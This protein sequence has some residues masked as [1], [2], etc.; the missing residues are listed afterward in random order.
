MPPFRETLQRVH[1]YAH[2]IT[3]WRR[4]ARAAGLKLRPFAKAGDYTLY[5]LATADPATPAHYVSA[6]IH[7]DEAAGAEALLR[8]A[9]SRPARLRRTPLFLVPCLNPWGLVHNQRTDANGVD[10]NRVFD[11][12]LA[13]IGELKRLL[14]GRRF[15]AALCLHE[16]YDALGVYLYEI[17]RRRDDAVG[18]ALLDATRG[19]LPMDTRKRIEGREF[20]GGL[21]LRRIRP[22]RV[23]F[24][25]EAL[26]LYEHHTDHA[27]TFE[28]PSECSLALR[29]EA[30]T[31][32]LNTFI[33]H[34]GAA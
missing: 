17:C 6:S 23:P 24:H 16:D 1:Q 30:M 29:V 8:W 27:V 31:R 18:R 15:R 19:L 10:L 7:G 5:Y 26:Y 22:E 28:T 20:K 34:T 33:R 12:D 14:A 13:P 21:M 25:P 3:R 32:V 2:L 11:Q 4:A 9:E